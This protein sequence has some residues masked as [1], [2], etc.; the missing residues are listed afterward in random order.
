MFTRPGKPPF[1][2]GFPMVFL[3]FS[4]GFPMVFLWFSYGFPMDPQPEGVTVSQNSR[5]VEVHGDMMSADECLFFRSPKRM[6]SVYPL[7]MVIFQSFFHDLLGYTSGKRA[8]ITNWK[9]PPF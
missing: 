5:S 2:Y 4:Y 3:W 6:S 1:S 7:K 9:D 8:N